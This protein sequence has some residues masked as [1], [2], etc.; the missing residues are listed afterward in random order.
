MPEQ[1]TTPPW[2]DGIRALAEEIDLSARLEP[3]AA[4]RWTPGAA[5][6]PVLHL[7]DVSGIPFVCVVPGVEEYQHRA[8]VRAGTGE[9]FAAMTPPSEGYEDYCRSRLGLGSPRLVQTAGGDHDYA[10]ARA[11]NHG[12]AFEQI[13]ATARQAGGLALHPYMAIDEVWALA[14]RVAEAA[15]VPVHVLGPP[16]PALWLANDKGQLSE[17]VTRVL[18]SDWLVETHSAST[19]AEMAHHLLNLVRRHRKAGLKRTRCASATGNAVYDLSR[20]ERM[21]PE[22]IVD[23]VRAFLERT[24]WA[25]DEE[26]LVVAWERTDDSPST[27]L[28]V[29]PLGHGAPRLDGVFE[30]ILEGEEQVFLGSRPSRLGPEIDGTL[31]EASLAVASALQWMGYVGRCSFDFIVVGGGDDVRAKFTECN[32]RWG[33][34]STPMHLVE[35]LMPGRRPPYRAQDFMHRDLV[36]ATFPQVLERVGDALYDP[37]TGRGRYIFYNVGPLERHGKLDVI[38]LGATADEAEE[39]IHTDLPRRLGLG[40]S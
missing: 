11:C 9:L 24:E 30:Q 1:S 19:P 16:P 31:A 25:L 6:S 29:P 3:F 20:I 5:D 17:V 35:R 23:E 27:Q 32:G 13:A 8:R 40:V 28:W 7:E 14:R 36:G 21:R 4:Q 10:V 18:S 38:A 33:G 26:V 37:I 22:E 12:E 34:T 15:G 39:S 2:G